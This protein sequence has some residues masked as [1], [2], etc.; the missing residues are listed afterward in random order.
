MESRRFNSPR[1]RSSVTLASAGIEAAIF[2]IA[3][4]RLRK[5]KGLILGSIGALLLLLEGLFKL[6]SLSIGG[7]VIDAVLLVVIANGLRGAWALRKGLVD[8]SEVADVFN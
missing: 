3:G 6:A 8:P 5:G 2:L 4:W 1:N 7:V